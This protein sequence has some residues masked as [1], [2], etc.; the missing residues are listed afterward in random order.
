MDDGRRAEHPEAIKSRGQRVDLVAARHTVRREVLPG[1]SRVV[2]DDLKPDLGLGEACDLVKPKAALPKL[3]N[4]VRAIFVEDR[5]SE[6]IPIECQGGIESTWRNS[7]GDI[8]A[9]P[10]V[11]SRV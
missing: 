5:Q 11:R 1:G 9:T 8:R 4:E 3:E 10:E 7:K 6:D 2:S